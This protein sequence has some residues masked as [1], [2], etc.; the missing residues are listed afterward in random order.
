MIDWPR[1]ALVFGAFVL[2][3]AALHIL[4]PLFAARTE[5]RVDDVVARSFAMPLLATGYVAA[6]WQGHIAP[7]WWATEGSDLGWPGR[8]GLLVSGTLFVW[9]VVSRVVAR[10]LQNR[11]RSSASEIDDVAVPI[12]TRQI[13]PTALGSLFL[14]LCFWVFGGS[15]AAGIATAGG[16]SF[17]LA[18]VLQEPL[19]NLFAGLS[20]ALDVPFTYGDLITLEDGKTY[21]VRRIGIRVT[22]LYDVAEH[23]LVFYP[24]SRLTQQRLINLVQPNV[25]QRMALT[26]GVAYETA[27][28]SGAQEI[29]NNIAL[30]H[31]HVLGPLSAKQPAMMA[32]VNELRL[33]DRNQDADR[34]LL[35]V[36]RLEYESKV[37]E[38]SEDL[39][40]HLELLQNTVNHQTG[41]FA[42][43]GVK[44]SLASVEFAL[45]QL[46]RFLVIWNMVL[47]YFQL[48]YR[49]PNEVVPL[50]QEFE[51]AFHE[52][53]V[54]LFAQE[55]KTYEEEHR[56]NVQATKGLV[57]RL[58]KQQLGEAQHD[59][60]AVCDSTHLARQKLHTRC[61]SLLKPIWDAQCMVRS[62][63]TNL[64]RRAPNEHRVQ[65]VVHDLIVLAGRRFPQAVGHHRAPDTSVSALSASSIDLT[66]DL[67][68]D[69]IVGDYYERRDDVKT[70]ILAEVVQKFRKANISIP[71]AHL[72]VSVVQLPTKPSIDGVH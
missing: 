3:A 2:T 37:R 72:D 1:F 43:A 68:V 19:T 54:G 69:D 34:L 8:L 61:Q 51:I 26:I 63:K 13:L 5:S 14:L 25:E 35:D 24:N 15:V 10:F 57:D 55:S 28:L 58:A 12:L 32:R 71:Y 9:S 31:P 18:Y 33:E 50:P 47:G 16:L 27:D 45:A 30:A 42:P 20:L 6:L 41:R 48:S 40:R 65:E 36:V 66:V 4:L 22:H 52:I 7:L 62:L 44:A 46:H 59:P 53:S 64:G 29:L 60:K 11:S 56:R 23:N 67:F 49:E 17:F 39:M 21:E 38:A 70:E